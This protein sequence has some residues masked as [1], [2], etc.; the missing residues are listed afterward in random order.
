MS[1]IDPQLDRRNASARR[2]VL[3]SPIIETPEVDRFLSRLIHPNVVK[4]Y[5]RTARLLLRHRAEYI[6]LTWCTATLL[7]SMLL[8]FMPLNILHF[9]AKRTVVHS[10][11]AAPAVRVMADALDLVLRDVGPVGTFFKASAY[12]LFAPLLVVVRTVTDTY[13]V[14]MVSCV[15][16]VSCVTLLLVQRMLPRWIRENAKG[17]AAAVAV[18][19]ITGAALVVDHVFWE[20]RAARFLGAAVVHGHSGALFVVVTLGALAAAFFT[21]IFEEDTTRSTT[22]NTSRNTNASNQRRAQLV[23]TAVCSS[24]IAIAFITVVRLNGPAV[25]RLLLRSRVSLW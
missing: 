18:A 8:A 7:F 23:Y 21:S 5:T 12:L 15:V 25:T 10:L 22:R 11:R 9:F 2:I 20:S 24:A 6:I 14:R 4:A 13:A 1:I 19:G 16:L 17:A 3:T